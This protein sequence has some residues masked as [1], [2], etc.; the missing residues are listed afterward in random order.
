[1][2]GPFEELLYTQLGVGRKLPRKQEW[3]SKDGRSPR[4]PYK[5]R[6]EFLSAGRPDYVRENRRGQLER[7]QLFLKSGFSPVSGESTHSCSNWTKRRKSNFES[8]TAESRYRNR[9]GRGFSHLHR[10]LRWSDGENWQKSLIFANLHREQFIR[11]VVARA[12]NC[13]VAENCKVV[14][15]VL[16]NSFQI[17]SR[18]HRRSLKLGYYSSPKIFLR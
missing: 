7:S 2:G 8:G 14:R 15:E 18:A 4:S 16:A 11:P 10:R 1:V 13:A 5:F 12:L 3:V 17:T 9:S 6:W